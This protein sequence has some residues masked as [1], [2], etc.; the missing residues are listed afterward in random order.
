MLIEISGIKGNSGQGSP[1]FSKPGQMHNTMYMV[2]NKESMPRKPPTEEVPF[3]YNRWKQ[4]IKDIQDKKKF[5][6]ELAKYEKK[7]HRKE[8]SEKLMK[9]G[10]SK[11]VPKEGDQE[12]EKPRNKKIVALLGDSKKDKLKHSQAMTEAEKEKMVKRER[13]MSRNRATT[14]VST[15]SYVFPH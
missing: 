12:T 10:L 1:V 9:L 2:F 8:Q 13:E 11:S 15:T 3:D 6:K 14:M 5:E 7:Q 4:D